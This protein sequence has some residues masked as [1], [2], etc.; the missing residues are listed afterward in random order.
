VLEAQIANPAP[1]EHPEILLVEHAKT[2]AAA[3][4]KSV[5]PRMKSAGLQAVDGGTLQFFSNSGQHLRRGIVGV[6]ERNNFVR[7]RVTFANQISQ[8]LRED[9][10]LPSTRAGN[11]QQRPMNVSDGLLLSLIGNDLR[12]R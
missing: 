4:Q 11:H 5:T 9:G 6:S 2:S 8:A 1:Q 7:A 12:R 3:L 10:R